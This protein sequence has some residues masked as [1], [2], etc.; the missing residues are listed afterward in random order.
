MLESL[1]YMLRIVGTLF[2]LENMNTLAFST[3]VVVFPAKPVV[4]V[5]ELI[6]CCKSCNEHYNLVYSDIKDNF[7]LNEK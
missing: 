2:L 6:A 1:I 3:F 5:A 4:I 7:K